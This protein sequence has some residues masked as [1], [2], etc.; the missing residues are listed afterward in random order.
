LDIRE[1]DAVD[2]DNRGLEDLCTVSSPS[3][4][5]EKDVRV[6]AKIQKNTGLE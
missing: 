6:P 5:P 1:V 2:A 3:L 4:L